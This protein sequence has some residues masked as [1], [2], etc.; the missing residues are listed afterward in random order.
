M[1]DDPKQSALTLLVAS[2]AGSGT[3]PSVVRAKMAGASDR[4]FLP[5]IAEELQRL[6]LLLLTMAPLES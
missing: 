5:S 1:N 2:K 4:C 3:P 6:L